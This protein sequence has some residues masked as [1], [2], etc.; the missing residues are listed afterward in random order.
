MY[1][2]YLF[3]FVDLSFNLNVLQLA[4]EKYEFTET[5]LRG[6]CVEDEEEITGLRNAE[7][8]QKERTK[9]L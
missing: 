3:S 6:L 8:E 5:F 9:N 4:G 1:R 7:K 2:L